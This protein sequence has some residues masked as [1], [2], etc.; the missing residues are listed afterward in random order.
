MLSFAL[1]QLIAT[2]FFPPSRTFDVLITVGMQR[3]LQ[4]TALLLLGAI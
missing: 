4:H 3:K 2:D 1:D